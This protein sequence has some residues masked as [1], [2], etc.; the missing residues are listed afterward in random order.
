MVAVSFGASR[1]LSEVTGSKTEESLAI[2]IPPT[3]KVA[4]KTH[5]VSRSFAVF[6]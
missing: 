1:V 6:I 5:R 4:R 3:R 2:A